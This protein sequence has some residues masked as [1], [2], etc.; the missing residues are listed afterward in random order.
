M[1]S[2]TPKNLYKKFSLG[3]P[4]CYIPASILLGYAC[5]CRLHFYIRSISFYSKP[6]KNILYC[7]LYFIKILGDFRNSDLSLVLVIIWWQVQLRLTMHACDIWKFCK[8]CT[9]SWSNIT[10]LLFIYFTTLIWIIFTA[11]IFKLSYRSK[12]YL[13]NLLRLRKEFKSCWVTFPN[14]FFIQIDHPS[15]KPVL[16]YTT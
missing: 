7:Y 8:N 13:T 10:W 1:S 14:F 4:K 6:K 9:H 3:S 16:E 11:F 2:Y 5:Y 15:S 12:F